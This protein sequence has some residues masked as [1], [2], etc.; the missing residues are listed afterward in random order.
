M[1]AMGKASRLRREKPV[2]SSAMGFV[3]AE[4]WE[5]DVKKPLFS[6]DRERSFS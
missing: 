4:P 5:H 1:E 2:K 3:E 6:F